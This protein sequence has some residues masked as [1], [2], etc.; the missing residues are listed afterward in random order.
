MQVENLMA[1]EGVDV[2][3]CPST[4]LATSPYLAE[5]VT[6]KKWPATPPLCVFRLQ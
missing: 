1:G 6:F 2:V 4:P 5:H 3:D